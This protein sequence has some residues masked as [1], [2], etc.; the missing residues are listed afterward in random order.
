LITRAESHASA[1]WDHTAAI[2]AL[3]F[4]ANRGPKTKAAKVE[5]FHP[6]RTVV[7]KPAMTHEQLHA[8]K[9]LFTN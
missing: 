7:A 4:N 6:F 2:L 3:I 1:S 9:P 8:L 5:D